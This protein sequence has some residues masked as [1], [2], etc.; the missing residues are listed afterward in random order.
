MNDLYIFYN[1]LPYFAKH[2][3][4]FKYSDREVCHNYPKFIIDNIKTGDIIFVKTDLLPFF[5][6]NFDL[7]KNK[8]I[9]FTGV[10]DLPITEIYYPFL[11][12]EKI[13]KW[14]GTNILIQHEKIFKIPIGFQ[15][16]ELQGGNQEL[17]K[18][19]YNKKLD[20]ENKKN[21]LF[22]TNMKITHDRRKNIE[23]L[24]NNHFC[25]I[26]K[27]KLLF[28]DYMEEINKYKFVLCPRGN[29]IDTHRFCE[30]L[31]MGSVPIVESSGLDDLYK[32]FPCI[33]LNSFNDININLLKSYKY[34]TEKEKNI[35]NYLN[36]GNLIEKINYNVESTNK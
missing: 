6:K 36:I 26:S 14:V 35:N 12:N 30:I 22:I 19:L 5:F 27:N 16:K 13:I 33:I 18:I 25:I 1:F 11:N 23:L 20:F 9:L 3:L 29:G 2:I 31:L 15:E 24:Y 21:N 7:I 8:F 34:E 32:N 4:D 28:N 17:L 10:S